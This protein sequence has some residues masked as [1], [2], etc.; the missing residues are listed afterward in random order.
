MAK[1]MNGTNKTNLSKAVFTMVGGVAVAA[2]LA[3]PAAQASQVVNHNGV[4]TL[5]GV[6]KTTQKISLPLPSKSY[7]LT[8]AAGPRCMPVYAGGTVHYGQD[9]GA[10]EGTPI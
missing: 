8:S 9:L 5:T 2:T 10:P 4:D 6:Q 1:N 7:A 3:A